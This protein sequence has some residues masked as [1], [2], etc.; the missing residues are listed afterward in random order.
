MKTESKK[1]S[2]GS[3]SPAVLADIDERVAASLKQ[4]RQGKWR[5]PLFADLVLY[6]LKTFAGNARVLDIGCGNGFDNS[7]KLQRVL[8]CES[9]SLCGIEPDTSIQRLEYFNQI[10]N[11]SFEDA[12]LSES[13]IDV[14]YAV[15]VLEHLKHPK[16]FWDKLRYILN[17]GG[18]FWGFTMDRRHYFTWASTLL[19][20]VRVKD[21]Y[22]RFV[23][24][25]E[26]YENYPTH[27]RCNTPRALKRH[28]KGFSQLQCWSWNSPGQLNGYVP[29]RL[30]LLSHAIDRIEIAC[31]LPGSLLLVR[32]VL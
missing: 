9:H 5:S 26:H 19:E 32:A 7:E 10:Y 25:S 14:A 6:D 13:S 23:Q 3:A 2:A 29:R 16:L 28:A 24:G 31:N 27:Y 1:I 17:P 4:Y 22:L 12:P 20:T 15:F 18:V 21:A 30:R 11:C 8:A